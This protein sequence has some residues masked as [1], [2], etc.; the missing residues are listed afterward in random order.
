MIGAQVPLH[1]LRV[2]TRSRR[3]LFARV[4][5]LL[6]YRIVRIDSRIFLS[7]F[8]KFRSTI[9]L[10]LCIVAINVPIIHYVKIFHCVSWN[11][12]LPGVSLDAPRSSIWTCPMVNFEW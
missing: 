9:T 11:Y 2:G 12:S 10:G 4:A 5:E 3:L 6:R 8:E 1:F 7:G